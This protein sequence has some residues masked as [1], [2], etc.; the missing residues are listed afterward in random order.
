[1]ESRFNLSYSP[2]DEIM[3]TVGASEGIDLAMRA[4]LNP[5]DEVLVPEPSY[6]SYY[7]CVTLAGGKAV[8]IKTSQE[9]KFKLTAESIEDVITPKT[10]AIILPYPNN[11]T[12]GIMTR[13]DLI[14]IVE[15]LKKHD[16]I[17]ISD[18]IYAELT[19]S[20]ERHVSIAEFPEMYERTVV[21]NGFSKAFAMTGWRMGYACGNRDIIS[22][23][24]K[25]HQYTMLCAPIMS[26]KA[27][28]EGLRYGLQNDF[29]SVGKMKRAYNRRRRMF[30]TQIRQIGLDCFEP[31]GAFYIF[32]SIK[33]TGFTSEEFCERLLEEEKV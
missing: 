20:D 1:M 30:V 31:E 16:I 33:S 27:A 18:E 6:V 19:Y 32:P 15:L 22:A 8:G 9:V 17:V 21:L 23:M 13:E 4:I 25:I 2:K 5:G 12:G 10:R 7:P 29:P 28:I 11:P 24:L 26:Q 14:P 3:V